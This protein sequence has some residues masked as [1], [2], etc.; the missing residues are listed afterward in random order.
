MAINDPNPQP[1]SLSSLSWNSRQSFGASKRALSLNRSKRASGLECIASKVRPSRQLLFEDLQLHQAPAP[2]DDRSM[3]LD[4]EDRPLGPDV[5]A[6]AYPLLI[7]E[8]AHALVV[9]GHSGS[10]RLFPDHVPHPD[11]LISLRQSHLDE[12]LLTRARHASDDYDHHM[13]TVP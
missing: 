10:V 2:I 5:V 9:P 3:A 1:S 8:T 6:M 12:L 13:T 7:G 4:M 11:H